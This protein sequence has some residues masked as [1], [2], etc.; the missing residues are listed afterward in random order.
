MYKSGFNGSSEG[1]QSTTARIVRKRM[2]IKL[3]A[4]QTSSCLFSL[5]FFGFCAFSLHTLL[6]QK[7]A[8]MFPFLIF[9]TVSGTPLRT[10][11]YSL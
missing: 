3:L 1:T 7:E 5:F 11:A 2:E 8:F 9:H 6:K 4:E 10:T